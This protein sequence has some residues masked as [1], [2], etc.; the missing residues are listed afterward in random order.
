MQ[1]PNSKPLRWGRHVEPPRATWTHEQWKRIRLGYV[2]NGDDK[3][4]VLVDGAWVHF[5]RSWTGMRVFSLRF[6]SSENGWM[7]AEAIVTGDRLNYM[8]IPPR[9][10]TLMI[11]WLVNGVLLGDWA[12]PSPFQ[13]SDM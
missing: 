11:D 5:Q 13:G 9:A 8:A 6:T 2:S 7:I 3:W 10:E 12:K 1:V 4:D